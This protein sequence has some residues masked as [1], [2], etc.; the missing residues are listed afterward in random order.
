MDNEELRL[1]LEHLHSQLEQTESI[2]EKQREILR[3]LES[4]IQELLSREQNQPHHYQSLGQR[5]NDSVAQFEAS[6]PQITLLMRRAI[7]SLSYLGV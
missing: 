1:Q 7:D 5:L 4:D 3:T 6:H 2:D